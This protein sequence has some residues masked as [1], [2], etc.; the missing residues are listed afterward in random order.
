M[1]SVR[2]LYLC[3]LLT[4]GSLLIILEGCGPKA[5]SNTTFEVGGSCDACPKSRLDTLLTQTI[6]VIKVDYDTISHILAVGFDSNRVSQQI[7]ID[8]LN[9]AG[10]DVNESYAL[11]PT[12]LDPCCQVSDVEQD[13]LYCDNCL[14]E[15]DPLGTLNQLLGESTDGSDSLD[16]AT[17]D[18]ELRGVLEADLMHGGQDLDLEKELDLDQ[19]TGNEHV[20]AGGGR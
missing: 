19:D 13:S 8:V 2:S 9:D 5:N 12:I 7:L 11:L 17:L 15:A 10:Y 20:G 16:E 18:K 6:G 4:T 1:V 3:L 14:N